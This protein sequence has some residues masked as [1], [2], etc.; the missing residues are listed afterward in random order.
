MGT[1]PGAG[2]NQLWWSQ[3]SRRGAAALKRG[4]TVGAVDW[5][6]RLA[7]RSLLLAVLCWLLYAGS[8]QLQSSGLAAQARPPLTAWQL[9]CW[10]S[11]QR[12]QRVASR[13]HST[14][15]LAP[16]HSTKTLSFRDQKHGQGQQH[17]RARAALTCACWP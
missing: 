3:P 15:D 5:A 8:G 11:V 14:R 1:L 17:C 13:W 12:V 16:D 6:L 7:G 4:Q 2:P 10:P 9:L